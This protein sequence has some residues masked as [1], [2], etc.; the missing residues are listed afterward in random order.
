MTDRGY[1]GLEGAFAGLN[2]FNEISFLI[3]SLINKMATVELVRVE[4]VTGGRVNIR[5][6]VSQVDG[7]GKGTDHGIIYNVPF[8]RLQGGNG[9]MKLD[10][11]V[12]DIGAA[13][14]CGHDSSVVKTTKAPGLPGSRRRFDWADALYLGG[15][16]N[17]DPVRYVEMTAG[18]TTI[19]D[20]TTVTIE[21][22]TTTTTGDLS[23][24]GNLSVT[25]NAAVG[26]N[27]S[28]SGNSTLGTGATK[29]VM[30]ADM[31]PSTTVKAK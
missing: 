4:G 31:T 12:G 8:F 26:G 1:R 19:H 20:P 30:L 6:L 18:G 2:H 25:G 13:L 29:F 11:V 10:P 28:V 27:L 22:P 9:A 15:Y 21:S 24:G 3:Q 17:G 23:I 14:F 16:L 7:D 5:P